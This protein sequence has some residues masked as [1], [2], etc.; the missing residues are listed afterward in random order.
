MSHFSTLVILPKDTRENEVKLAAAELLAPF[1]ENIEVE[2]YQEECWCV[3]R[4]ARMD[5]KL[6]FTPLWDAARKTFDAQHPGGYNSKRE[7]LWEQHTASLQAE[8]AAFRKN[9]PKAGQPSTGCE[10]CQGS[11]K[12]ETQ[13]NPDSKWDWWVVGGRWS[14]IYRAFAL[15]D[16]WDENWDLIDV[17]KLRATLHVTKDLYAKAGWEEEA[18]PDGATTPTYAVV[19][20]NGDWFGRGSMGWFGISHCDTDEETFWTGYLDILLRYCDCHA[21]VCDLHI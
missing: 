13:Y 2:P 19:T 16:D 9:H 4:E 12:R 14:G 3:G 18:L 11:G 10:D 5:T 17:G 6:K 1:D 8:E 20:P 7:K 15:N 21:V